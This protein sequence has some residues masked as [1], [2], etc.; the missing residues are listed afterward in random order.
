MPTN[1]SQHEGAL[2]GGFVILFH[3]LLFLEKLVKTCRSHSKCTSWD[4]I[5]N[6]LH[7]FI[8]FMSVI[9][10]DF[11]LKHAVSY[12]WNKLLGQPQ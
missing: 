7:C 10:F 2:Y 12:F 5:S 4:S 11:A 6:Q 9:L 1:A 3:C 8:L